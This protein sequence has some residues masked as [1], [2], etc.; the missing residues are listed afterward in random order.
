MF[1]THQYPIYIRWMPSDTDI[2]YLKNSSYMGESNILVYRYAISS[3][4]AGIYTFWLQFVLNIVY[5]F[6]SNFQTKCKCIHAWADTNKICIGQVPINWCTPFGHAGIH[7]RVSPGS[8]H[9]G[10]MLPVH[11]LILDF[12]IDLGRV[13]NKMYCKIVNLLGL[14]SYQK[15][16][17][18]VLINNQM[19]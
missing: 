11:P 5:T 8:V 17:Q 6:R 16:N 19:S 12:L 2:W 10:C 15:K 1:N 18:S 7:I 14:L 4:N 3:G 13:Q 9:G